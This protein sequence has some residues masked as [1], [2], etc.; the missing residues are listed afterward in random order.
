[1]IKPS[2]GFSLIELMIVVAIVGIIATI[3]YPAYTEQ[4][5]RGRQSD[6][7]AMLMEVMQAQE[8]F[9]SQNQTYTTNLTALGYA[10]AN[11]ESQG[12]FYAIAAAAC[13]GSAVAQ[14][15]LLT[16]TAQGA[17]AGQPNLTYNSVS[18]PSW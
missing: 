11:P 18:G 16:A 14:C 13:P 8:R 9:Y 12:D 1:M 17:Q 2:S 3:A 6:G 4:A 5:A 10:V 15:V 7:Q